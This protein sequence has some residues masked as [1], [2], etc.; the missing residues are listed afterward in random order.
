MREYFISESKFLDLNIQFPYKE[1]LKEAI[2]LKN[3]YH[4]CP[5]RILV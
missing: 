5:P 1:M 2:A 4:L 3:R